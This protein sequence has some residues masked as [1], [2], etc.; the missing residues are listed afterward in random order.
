MCSPDPHRAVEVPCPGPGPL[1]LVVPATV[2]TIVIMKRTL[3]HL[4]ILMTASLVFAACSG[5]GSPDS[6][7]ESFD[8]FAEVDT[9]MLAAIDAVTAKADR[10]VSTGPVTDDV[11]DAAVAVVTDED[12]DPYALVW[13]FHPGSDAD[14]DAVFLVGAAGSVVFGEGFVDQESGGE[15]GKVRCI[16]PR[17]GALEN[18]DCPAAVVAYV[19]GWQGEFPA[20]GPYTETDPASLPTLGNAAWGIA[21]AAN[22]LGRISPTDPL[23]ADDIRTAAANAALPE[24]FTASFDETSGVVSVG[25]IGSPVAVCVAVSED[26]SRVRFEGESWSSPY[27]LVSICLQ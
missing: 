20:E 19:F 12:I 9:A 13:T 24:G 16:S 5:V 4:I 25:R 23:D 21:R 15:S 6:E 1:L 11:L 8:D 22:E 7:G 10:I 2:S 3:P 27:A 14:G 18:V 26:V 17:G